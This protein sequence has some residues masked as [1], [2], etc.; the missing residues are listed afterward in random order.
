MLWQVPPV[1]DA[2]F[3]DLWAFAA[4]HYMGCPERAYTDWIIVREALAHSSSGLSTQYY[5]SA[6]RRCLQL[7]D[8]QMAEGKS[9]FWHQQNPLAAMKE[10]TGG[11]WEQ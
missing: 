3:L 10:D 4:D 2:G 7:T 1:V 8:I 6:H 9:P 11:L 5:S